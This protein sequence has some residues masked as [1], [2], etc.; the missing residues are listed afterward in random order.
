MANG[1]PKRQKPPKRKYPEAHV[2][3]YRAPVDTAGMDP[4]MV[5]TM[6]G[7]RKMPK[8]KPR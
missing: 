8:M 7:K 3:G 5:K 2:G 1:Y 4:E 6:T